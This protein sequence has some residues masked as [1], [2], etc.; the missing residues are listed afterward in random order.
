LMYFVQFQILGVYDSYIQDKK[1][2]GV[3]LGFRAFTTSHLE[4]SHRNLTGN[5]VY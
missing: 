2:V 3:Y 5:V 4:I 1:V